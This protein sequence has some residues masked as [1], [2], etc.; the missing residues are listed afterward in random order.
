M[1][2]LSCR[3]RTAWHWF[4]GGRKASLPRLITSHRRAQGKVLDLPTQLLHRK[5]DGIHPHLTGLLRRL[6]R[7]IHWKN[8]TQ[9]PGHRRTSKGGGDYLYECSLYYL[10]WTLLYSVCFPS[11]IQLLSSAWWSSGPRE[12]VLFYVLLTY[13]S[14]KSL[15]PCLYLRWF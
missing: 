2:Q 7:V 12:G 3:N 14:L 6:Q 4:G 11:E 13:S 10:K 1:S 15:S 8:L 9:G 5:G